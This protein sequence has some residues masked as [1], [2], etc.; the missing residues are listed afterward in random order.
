MATTQT[1]AVADQMLK[2]EVEVFI[3][4]I[5]SDAIAASFKKGLV[6]GNIAKDYSALVSGGGDKINIPTQQ[7]VADAVSHTAGEVVDFTRRDEVDLSITVNQHYT[8]NTMLDDLAKIQSSYDLMSGYADSMGYKFA[9]NLEDALFTAASNGLNAVNMDNG[10]DSVDRILNKARIAAIVTYMYSQDLR[11]EEC[12]LVLSNRLYGS[13]FNLDDFV[14][15]GEIGNAN[16]PAGTVG[17]VMGIPVIPSPRIHRNLIAAGAVDEAGGNIDDDLYPGGFVI[18]K[19]GLMMA[20][21][22]YPTANAEYDMDYIAHK[23]VTDVVYGCAL[24]HDASVNQAR[25]F[26]LYEAGQTAASS[27]T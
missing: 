2:T 7:F 18:H 23:M 8:T 13:L 16:F 15:A 12:V 19:D 9:L 14:H 10:D 1:V 25:V 21:S 27:W 4:E 6:L 5:W 3:P 20:Y 17:T 24:M 22:K 11:P 26:A